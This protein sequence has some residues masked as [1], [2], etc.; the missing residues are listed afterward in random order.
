MKKNLLPLVMLL[1]L[2]IVAGTAQAVTGVDP[3]LGLLERFLL[4]VEVYWEPI[5]SVVGTFAVIAAAT[6]T[7]RDDSIVG[8]VSKFIDFLG[9]NIG[10]AKNQNTRQ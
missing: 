5:A 7:K 3:E 1:G 2:A 6:P 4:F 8:F 10:A 9:A